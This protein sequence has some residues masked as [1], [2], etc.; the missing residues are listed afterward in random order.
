MIYGLNN[1]GCESQ[2]RYGPQPK[3]AAAVADV[4]VYPDGLN[5]VFIGLLI[6]FRMRGMSLLSVV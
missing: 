5:N 1:C 6:L 3:P 4:V 2:C